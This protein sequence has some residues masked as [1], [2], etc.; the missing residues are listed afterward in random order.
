MR[1]SLLPTSLPRDVE[2]IA[3]GDIEVDVSTR[4]DGQNAPARHIAQW[5]QRR[6]NVRRHSERPRLW[7]RRREQP[8]R[9]G[10]VGVPHERQRTE[11][12]VHQDVDARPVR[13]HPLRQLVARQR[14][15]AP[16][17]RGVPEVWLEQR[18]R[19][20]LR[21]PPHADVDVVAPQSVSEI[22]H[23]FEGQNTPTLV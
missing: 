19:R 15:V 13:G 5:H 12:R 22:N 2:S 16:Q 9:D 3:V 7:P 6:R 4:V 14:E 23:D 8:H 1:R 10:V 18:E 20:S 11:K 21:P 17:Q